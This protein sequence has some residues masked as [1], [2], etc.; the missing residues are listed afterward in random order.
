MDDTLR[1]R[2]L[3]RALHATLAAAA[4]KPLS[5][6]ETWAA[7]EVRVVISQKVFAKLF[8]RSQFPHKLVNLIF[9]LV[10][11]KDELTGLCG[12]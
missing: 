3:V 10:I 6:R 8:C 9:L 1:D 5:Y 11:I 12:N 4:R 7:L 2:E